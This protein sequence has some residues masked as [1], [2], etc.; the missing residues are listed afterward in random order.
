M[1]ILGVLT[2]QRLSEYKREQVCCH[3]GPSVP[4]GR[5]AGM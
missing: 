5:E 2:E 3:I 1:V 4:G